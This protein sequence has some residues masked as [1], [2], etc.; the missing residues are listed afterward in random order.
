MKARGNLFIQYKVPEYLST[1][2][3]NHWNLFQAPFYRFAIDSPWGQFETLV[4]LERQVGLNALVIYASPIFHTVVDLCQKDVIR[5]SLLVK[6]S[7]LEGH[8]RVMYDGDKLFGNPTPA[9]IPV[10]LPESYTL[11]DYLGMYRGP[12]DSDN[13]ESE[14]IS[15]RKTIENILSVAG[16][17]PE[18]KTAWAR[19][20]P[21]TSTWDRA[22][23]IRRRNESEE[24]P[25]AQAH[26]IAETFAFLDH[27]NIT[28]LELT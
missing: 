9:E 17:D 6:P 2:R 12:A 26:K 19:I 25:Q 23:E 28:W 13:P 1:K 10:L 15:F 4:D 27:K 22:R 16:Q 5:D 3:A 21:F 11:T 7:D 24:I 14:G 18:W 8:T 20:A